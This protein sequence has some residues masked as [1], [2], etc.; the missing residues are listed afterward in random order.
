[1]FTK[2]RRPQTAGQSNISGPHFCR[3]LLLAASLAALTTLA[4]YASSAQRNTAP[5]QPMTGASVEPPSKKLVLMGTVT[6]ISPVAK[7]PS[8]R[9]WAI[10]IRVEKVKVG[11]FSHPE[12]TFT[13][14]S[15]SR[16]GLEVGGHCTIEANWTGRGYLVKDTRRMGDKD[17]GR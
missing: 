4:A 14:H 1:M 10:T 5:T 13:V 8:R 17:A 15:P 3:R 7:L 11:K 9:N 6:A 2:V 12:F 16:A